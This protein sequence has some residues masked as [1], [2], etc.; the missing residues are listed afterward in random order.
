MARVSH[1]MRMRACRATLGRCP[2]RGQPPCSLRR[3]NADDPSRHAQPS[4]RPRPAAARAAAQP[5]VRGGAPAG[6]AAARDRGSRRAAR[7][8]GAARAAARGALAAGAVGPPVLLR[9]GAACAPACGARGPRR[10]RLPGIAADRVR[11]AGPRLPRRLERRP[12]PPL[13][14]RHRAGRRAE[15]GRAAV[16]GLRAPRQL[17]AL[18]G[19]GVPRLHR[20][21]PGA[22]GWARPVATTTRSEAGATG[23]RRTTR[24][25]MRTGS[26]RSS[27]SRP[28][29]SPRCARRSTT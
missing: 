12:A 27:A 24:S 8:A 20:G 21:A 5:R 16:Q 2:A 18:A 13:S 10:G 19:R 7:R 28:S 15:L 1:I 4:H 23:R 3:R 9:R 26:R 17:R 25:P 14:R 6:R 11:A 22:E 29:G